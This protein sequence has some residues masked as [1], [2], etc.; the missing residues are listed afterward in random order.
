M[1]DEKDRLLSKI[2]YSE[3]EIME[4]V[5][6]ARWMVLY[7]EGCNHGGH[8]PEEEEIDEAMDLIDDITNGHALLSLVHKGWFRFGPIKDGELTYNV[9]EWGREAYKERDKGMD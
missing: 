3:T 6:I 5:A 9:T 8:Y 4:E 7:V 1:S 2:Q